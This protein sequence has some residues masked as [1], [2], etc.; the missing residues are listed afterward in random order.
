MGIWIYIYI[1][2]TSVWDG[3]SG[4]QPRFHQ[5]PHGGGISEVFPC[6]LHKCS[7]WES[8][9]WVLGEQDLVIFWFGKWKG[10]KKWNSS[11]LWHWECQQKIRTPLP[12]GFPNCFNLPRIF[13][14]SLKCWDT[15]HAPPSFHV[16]K[17]M[18]CCWM[19]CC[20][21]GSIGAPG[22]WQRHWGL[23]VPRRDIQLG[24]NPIVFGL[25]P[26]PGCQSQMKV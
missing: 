20:W 16:W 12:N 6:L 26:H 24:G 7:C 13:G 14:P 10:K 8:R 22:G 3:K 25:P 9:P 17:S 11:N 21:I 1:D 2:T 4:Q 18:P 23:A 15:Y 5:E 19:P